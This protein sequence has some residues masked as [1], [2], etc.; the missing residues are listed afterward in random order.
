MFLA[1]KSQEVEEEEGN[2]IIL[3]EN[4][5]ALHHDELMDLQKMLV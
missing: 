1:T 5:Q 2:V 4:M 3:E